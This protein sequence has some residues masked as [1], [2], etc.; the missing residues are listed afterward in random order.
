MPSNWTE[1]PAT[2]SAP[3]R[4]NAGLRLL[5]DAGRLALLRRPQTH[6]HPLGIGGFTVAAGVFL[7]CGVLADD[8]SIAT[9]RWWNVWAATERSFPLLLSLLGSAWLAAAIDRRGIELRLAAVFLLALC[10]SQLLWPWLQPLLTAWLDATWWAIAYVSVLAWQ[11]ARWAAVPAPSPQ[12]RWS[13]GLLTAAL[14]AGVTSWLPASP[15]WW[16]ADGEDDVAALEAAVAPFSAEQLWNRQPALLAAALAGLQ[17]QRPGQVDLYTIGMAGDGAEGVFR[18]EV[19][20]LERLLAERL[21]SPGR[22]LALVNHPEQIERR[23]LASMSNLRHALDG[24]AAVMDRDEDILLLFVTSHGS[25]DHQ[26]Y[27]G[28]DPLP[29]D[30]LEPEALRQALDEVGI[31]WRVL[32]LSACYSGGFVDRLRSPESLIITAARADRPSFGCGVQSDIT[33]FGEAFLSEAL[34]QTTDFFEAFRLAKARIA[35]REREAGERPSFPQI[36]RGEAIGGQLARWRG[37][38]EAGPPVPFAP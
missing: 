1:L 21:R 20:F 4:L 10:P 19:D 5:G 13:A 2:A 34:N 17:P 14:A 16:T 11:A 36:A 27:L 8:L 37:S 26:I 23:P 28:L 35:E 22:M 15:W 3:S 12:R 31:R 6:L 7:F 18:N 9:P 29:L 38:V 33:W 32:V 24:V 30:P 25:E